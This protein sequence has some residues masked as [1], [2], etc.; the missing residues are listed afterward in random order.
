MKITKCCC[1]F[2]VRTGAYITII[3]GALRGIF[4]L[5]CFLFILDIKKKIEEILLE[6]D[7]ETE[8]DQY[9]SPLL[10]TNNKY[11]SVYCFFAG[12]VLFTFNN[13]LLLFGL[14]RNRPVCIQIW[15]LIEGIIGA[16]S[17]LSK[18]LL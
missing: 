9:F 1:C 2:D 8:P 6:L 12:M 17:L 18:H 16:V 3:F 14:M 11:F 7:S 10:Q 13:V 4:Y 5:S 15:L